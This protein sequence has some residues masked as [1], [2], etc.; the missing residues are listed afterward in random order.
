M[1]IVSWNCAGGFKKKYHLLDTLK[2]D[3]LIIQECE[4]P[5]R[6]TSKYYKDWAQ[7]Y[8]WKGNNKNKGIGIF[9]K[10]HFSLEKL[11]W[12]NSFTLPI[13][14][15]QSSCHTWSTDD[16][17]LFLPF[18]YNRSKTII[19]VWTKSADCK[20]F[21]YIGQVWKFLQLHSQELTQ[22]NNTS[23]YLIGDFN[24]NRIWDGKSRW[25]NHSDVVEELSALGLTSLYHHSRMEDHGHET[26]P[27][28]YMYRKPEKPYHIDYAFCPEDT[29]DA[30]KLT[31]GDSQEWLNHSD[32]VPLIIDIDE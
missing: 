9:T 20:K 23:N 1:R 21:A 25:K 2:F 10:K 30:H 26:T 16:L 4:D 5:A 14:K 11:E 19:G 31:I 18:S 13:K 28:F 12:S 27:T 24:S 29:L 7:N 8:L 15:D 3:L 32:H 17:E 6:T 22:N